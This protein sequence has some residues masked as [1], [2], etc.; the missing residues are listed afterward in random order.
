MDKAERER[1][2]LERAGLLAP[3]DNPDGARLPPPSVKKI[4][5]DP[6]PIKAQELM[7]VD[8]VR[9]EITP[10]ILRERANREE[11]ERLEFKRKRESRRKLD[12]KVR[13]ERWTE[14]V[15]PVWRPARVEALPTDL[16]E[17]AIGWLASEA[18]RPNIILSGATGVGKSYTAYALARELYVDHVNMAIR[19]VAVLLDQIKPQVEG[20]ERTFEKVKTCEVLILEDL[21]AERHTGTGW[22]DERLHLIIDHRWQWKL[23]TIVTTNVK[24]EGL[25]ELLGDRTA[26]RLMDGAMLQVIK[27]DDRRMS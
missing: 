27:G 9:Q 13:D 6:K 16:R 21:G 5:I 20:A 8:P 23:P 14:L 19:E 2:E 25:Y 24:L 7:N 15:A 3:I 18:P 4:D 17:F 26:S 10:E 12:R 11:Q 1:Q 22:A